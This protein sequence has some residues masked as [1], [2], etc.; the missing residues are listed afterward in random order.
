VR[1][2]LPVRPGV[3]TELPAERHLPGREC[4]IRRRLRSVSSADLIVPATRCTTMGD[5]AFAVTAPHA[6]NILPEAI[7]RSPSLATFK[8]C[9]KTH[10]YVEFFY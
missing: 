9:L 8:C 1:T 6:W 7:R 3:C 10:F 4:G 2:G 5:R